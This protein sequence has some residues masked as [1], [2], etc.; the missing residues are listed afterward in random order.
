MVRARTV[1][2]LILSSL[3]YLRIVQ[4]ALD[5]KPGSKARDIF[6]ENPSVQLSKL[7]DELNKASSASSLLN[8]V[9][10]D[11]EKFAKNFG[12]YKKKGSKATV[13]ALLTFTSVDADIPVNK[14]DLCT[15]KNGSSF[16][17]LNGFI[18]SPVLI[19]NYRATASR[20]RADLDFLGITDQYAV[21]V[22]LEATSSGKQGNISKYSLTSTNIVGVNKVTN[23]FQ[24]GGGSDT[25][26]DATFKTRVLAVFSGANIG[27]ALGY[28]NAILQD[29]SVIDA[30][31]V[32]PGDTLM[33]RDGTQVYTDESNNK[34]IISE[35]TGGKVDIYV[36]GTRLQQ[37]TD[38]YLFRDL[39]NTGD[40]TNTQ[41]DFVLGQ[42]DSDKN[43]TVTRKRIDNLASGILPLQ[44][45]NNI[46]S[47][48]GSLS[49]PNFIEKS[50]DSL[51]RVTGNYELIIDDGDYGGSPW[52]F[53]RLR[54]ISDRIS[55]FSED[56]TKTTFNGQDPLSFSDL[57]KISKIQQ[58]IIVT[59][60]NSKVNSANKSII[61]LA[62]YPVSSVTRVF[63]VTTGERYVISSQNPDGSGSVNKTGRITISGKSL[64]AVS[65]ILQVDYTWIF[66]FDPFFDF[67]NIYL[68]D[69]SRSVQDSIDWGYSNLVRREESLLLTSGS[70]LTTTVT[71]PISS[72]VSVNVFS[73]HSA[74]VS[75]SSDRLIVTVP[76]LVSNVVSIT[77]NSDNAEL[78]NTNKDDGTFKS[79][80]IF[81]PTD[82]I[83]S[84]GENVS[85][86]YN[87][88]DVFNADTQGSFNG[89]TITIVPSSTATAGT[90]VECTYIANIN[91]LLPSTTLNNLP[92]IR[93]TNYFTTNSS[94]NI[95]SQPCT[96][97]FNGSGE[98]FKNL[99]QAPSNLA[100]TLTGTFSP[101]TFLISGTS[102]TIIED[103]VLTCSSNGLSQNLST[104][105]KQFLNVNSKTSLSS[106]IKIARVCKVEKVSTSSNNEVLSVLTSYDVKGYKI[107]DNSFVKSEAIKD[108]LLSNTEFT[109]P[110]TSTNSGDLLEIGD[111]IRVSFH[112]MTVSDTETV[113]F[114]R[115]G[116]L[117]TNKKFGTIDTISISTGFTSS[118]SN[119]A[120]LVVTN[121]N[122]PN[123]KSR[124]KAYYDYL[125]PKTNERIS[126][127]YNTNKLIQ[128]S[129]ISLNNVRPITADVLV[130]GAIPLLVDATIAIVVTSEFSNSKTI[131]QQNVLDAVTA[132]L[133]ANSLGTTIDASDLVQV[134]YTVTGVDRAIVKVFNE[135]DSAG[136][137]LSITAQKNQYIFPNEISVEIEDR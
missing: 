4:P 76:D 129:T 56:K 68:S 7:Y 83:A 120:T 63:N 15:A 51:G 100:L 84:F 20:Y 64:P 79:Y 88:V 29:S 19:N 21:E 24:A 77:R 12:A 48:S 124:Y 34:T 133:Q 11:L 74:D 102:L 61:Q 89:N 113:S 106:N 14:G 99:R 28:R 67:D 1:N 40:P 62:H 135:T 54:W 90:T 27:T 2:E 3:D 97:I 69:N 46:V 57:L 39:S 32:E 73:T 122:Q 86:V 123:T 31:V 105:I 115:A 110:S 58:N 66:S 80:T 25:E 137:V 16:Q 35:G 8:S 23:V 91:T 92:A 26:T 10:S 6:V 128:D 50:T 36:Y 82:T 60:E 81:L 45:V 47:V 17:V 103:A 121:L 108:T 127:T 96:N 87:S 13:S 37:T 78:W 71:H 59:N 107:K 114:S 30:L 101:G 72:V 116:T 112:I 5:T 53:D 42:I 104:A 65:D 44:P 125:A 126:I 111:K 41:N 132:A 22:L 119:S 70:Y 117:Y 130:K 52:G 109:L 33:T 118:A 134:A 75:I 93:S 136:S 55:D 43:K 49:G 18:I 131:V 94:S 95:G 38:S 85:I 98:V 9:G